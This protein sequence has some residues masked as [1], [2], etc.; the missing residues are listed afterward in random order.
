MT[1]F[2]VHDTNSAPEAARGSLEQSAQAYGFVPNL[3]GVFAESPELL[4]AY[5]AIG[6]I[7]SRSGFD[8]AEQQIVLLAIKFENGCDYCMAAHSGI[9]AGAGVDRPTIDALRSGAELE[10][11]RLGA[12][13]RFTRLV[14]QQA[15]WVDAA[16]VDAF[17]AAGW[18]RR[19]VLDVIL[20]AAYKTMSNYTNHI[21]RTPLDAQFSA[22]AWTAPAATAG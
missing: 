21:A 11:V 22:N 6:E 5:K 13:V 3:H 1:T 12:L 16:D 20:A 18:E 2:T 4:E 14:V 9:A 19:H 7:F 10:D 15:G 8:P 17:L